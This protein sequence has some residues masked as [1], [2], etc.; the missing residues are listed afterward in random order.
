MTALSMLPDTTAIG[1]WA[2]STDKKPPNDWIELVPIGPLGEPLAGVTRRKRLEAGASQL[3]GLVGGGTALNDTTLAAYRHVLQGYDA[4]K[5]NSVVLM[6]DGRNDDVSSIDTGALIETLKRESD[7]AKPVPIIMVGLGDE[8]DMDAL[9]AISAA[10]GGKAYQARNPED[11]R[12]VLL[13][14]VSQRRCR[15]NC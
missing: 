6:T 5:V 8:V 15:P 12:G 4:S 7:P 3:P 14:A 11:I 2:F 13:D 10:T 9:R 1:L